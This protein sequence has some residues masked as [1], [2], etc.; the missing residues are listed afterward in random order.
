MSYF[1]GKAIK[2]FACKLQCDR[3]DIVV[4]NENIEDTFTKTLLEN[5][6]I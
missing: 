4:S 6:Q 3:R 2:L 5:L 1:Q